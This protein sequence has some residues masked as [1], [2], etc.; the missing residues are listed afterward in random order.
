MQMPEGL[1]TREV[2]LI[3]VQQPARG[4]NN[5][6]M[7]RSQMTANQA[8]HK[9]PVERFLFSGSQNGGPRCSTHEVFDRIWIHQTEITDLYV[10]PCDPDLLFLPGY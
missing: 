6:N 7:H 8:M 9:N 5:P 4:S 1:L 10:F 2:I 3:Y